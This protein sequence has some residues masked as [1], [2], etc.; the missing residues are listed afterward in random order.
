MVRETAPFKFNVLCK[1]YKGNQTDYQINLM[2]EYSKKYPLTPLHYEIEPLAG[3]TRDNINHIHKKIDEILLNNFKKPVVYDIVEETRAWIHEHL[4]EGR[5]YEEEEEK[6]VRQEAVYERPKFAAFTPVTVEN[7]LA[8]K[9]E[10][11]LKHRGDKEKI[12]KETEIKITGKEW[13]LGKG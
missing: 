7:F 2:F 1:P 6:I 9:K 13:F 5:S 11:D 10:F 3:I 8:W 4:V 12:K